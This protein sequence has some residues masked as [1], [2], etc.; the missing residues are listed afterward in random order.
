MFNIFQGND[1]INRTIAKALSYEEN[2]EYSWF[3]SDM[4]FQTFFY[5]SKRFGNPSSFDDC[6]EAGAWAFKVKGYVIEIRMNAS[7][8]EFMMYGR[9]GNTRVNSPYTVKYMRE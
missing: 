3:T 1:L 2:Q 8:V 6:K 7:W 5:L 4:Y 9:I